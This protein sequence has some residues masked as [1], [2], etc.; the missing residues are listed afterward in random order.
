MYRVYQGFILNN[1]LNLNVRTDNSYWEDKC[2]KEE[3]MILLNFK[4][5]FW[6]LCEPISMVALGEKGIVIV[7]SKDCS[8]AVFNETKRS[9]VDNKNYC[10]IPAVSNSSMKHQIEME[11]K[12]SLSARE[13]LV[14]RIVNGTIR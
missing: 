6:A 13:Q 12:S 11:Q 9:L 4:H 10:F 5:V 2:V 1:G 3:Q 8:T 7:I 14:S